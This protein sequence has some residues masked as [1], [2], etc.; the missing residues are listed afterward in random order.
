MP[1]SLEQYHQ[2]A[3]RAGRDGDP[4]ECVLFV[5]HD[6]M[7]DLMPPSKVLCKWPFQIAPNQQNVPL[8][9]NQVIQIN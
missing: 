4:A 6:A 5:N 9:I 3:G 1:Q 2:E 7:P 8:V